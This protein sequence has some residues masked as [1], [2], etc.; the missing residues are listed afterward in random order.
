MFPLMLASITAEKIAVA[1]GLK[2]HGAQMTSLQYM[3][4]YALTV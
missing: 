1:V 3:L 2:R 4:K